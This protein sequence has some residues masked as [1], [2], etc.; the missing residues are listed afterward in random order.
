MTVE[1]VTV[2]IFNIEFVI[3]EFVAPTEVSCALSRVTPDKFEFA[4]SH[5]VEIVE[6]VIAE[7]PVTPNA[8]EPAMLGE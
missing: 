8:A 4:M 7:F 3:E 5:H 2:Q 1:F 6:L